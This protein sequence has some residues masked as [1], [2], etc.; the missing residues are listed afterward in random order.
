MAR[1][2]LEKVKDQLNC[3]VCLDTYTD[4]KLL[5]CLHV[6]CQKCLVK[7]VVKDQQGQFSLTCP[8]CR[9]VTPVPANGV[10]GLQSAFHINRFLEI[11]EELREDVTKNFQKKKKFFFCFILY[12]S[13]ST[14]TISSLKQFEGFIDKLCSFLYLPLWQEAN[15]KLTTKV[16]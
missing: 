16:H 3:S 12:Y 7:L 9:Q 4:P 1:K 8:N 10:R 15:K 13:T 11:A 14:N 6:F 2:A 5:Q